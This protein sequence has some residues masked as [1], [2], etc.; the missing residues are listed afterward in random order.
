MNRASGSTKK[1]R[2]RRRGPSAA[3]R[4]ALFAAG[5]ALVPLLAALPRALRLE[6]ALVQARAPGP[7]GLSVP[8]GAFL[9]GAAAFAALFVAVKIPAIAYVAVHE[10][11]HAL[12]GLL[13]FSPVRRLR[14]AEEEGSVEVER[15][16]AMVLLA[17]YFFPLPAVA[18]L[19]LFGAVSLF[20]P[21]VGTAAG[22]VGA[23]VV[24]AAW[25]FHFCFTL[26]ALLQRQTDLDAYGFFF[27][28]VLLLA[29]NLAFLL[30]ALVALG[31][32]RLGPALGRLGE[33]AADSYLW[34][35]DFAVGR[36]RP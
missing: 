6:E 8:T 26:N 12:F 13:C 3:L 4:A 20:V 9:L 36:W 21:L 33:I 30:F 34:F 23:G 35:L 17:P 19:L 11:T 15:P 10:S 24:G 29:L 2:R 14:V 22:A 25:G 7:L 28:A 32:A 27:S 5:A 31:P 18:A 16:N 1:S